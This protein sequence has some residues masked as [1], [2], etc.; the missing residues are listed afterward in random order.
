MKRITIIVLSLI[1]AL[2]VI[3]GV[4]GQPKDPKDIE[5]WSKSRWGMTEEEILKAFKGKAVRL[6]EKETYHGAY[7]TIGINDLEID[8]HK[9]QVRF[10]M[11]NIKETLQQVNIKLK[12]NELSAARRIF[13]ELEVMLVEKHGPPSLK[14]A[15]KQ[16][17]FSCMITTW[18]FP[19]TVIKLLYLD[20]R[21]INLRMF[22]IIYRQPHKEILVKYDELCCYSTGKS[23]GN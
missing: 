7:A 12:D 3:S 18:N 6:K 4:F 19:T 20:I 9:Y 22:M 13:R 21:P 23:Y 14:T 16:K 17:D 15:Q 2:C 10:L 5:G 11:D 1:I 8:G